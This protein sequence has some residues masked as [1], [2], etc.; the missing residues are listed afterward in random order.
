MQLRRARHCSTRSKRNARVTRCHSSASPTSFTIY[1][2]RRVVL[3]LVTLQGSPTTVAVMVVPASMW[4][5]LMVIRVPP[6]IGPFFGSK[7]VIRGSCNESLHCEVTLRGRPYFIG[8][9]LTV[10]SYITFRSPGCN[11][12]FPCTLLGSVTMATGHLPRRRRARRT[13]H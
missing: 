13:R 12:V 4:C 3:Y 7:S 5:P 1:E 8:T 2:R 6:E 11:E 9:L 10:T